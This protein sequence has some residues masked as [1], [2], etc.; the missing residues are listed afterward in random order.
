VT[1][2]L[3]RHL[4]ADARALGPSSVP[5]AAY[6]L[7]KRFGG[8]GLLFG[9]LVPT[10]APAPRLT[11][12]FAVPAEIPAAA[13]GRAAAEAADL[14]A[15]KVRL[16]GREFAL[17][18]APNWCAMVEVA[19]CWPR[20]PWWTIDI[21]SPERPADVK[22]CWELGR[23]RHLVVLARAARMAPSSDAFTTLETHLRSWLDQNPPEVGIHWYSNLEVALR[24]IAWLQIVA[25][26]G[27][28]LPPDL[29]AAMAAVLYQSGRHL[30]AD[31]PYTLASMRNNHLLGD[32][33]GLVAVG[34][35]FPSDRA[36]RRW[37]ALGDR[38]FVRQAARL[39]RDD[40]SMLE[41]SLSYHRFVTEMLAARLLL[42]GAPDVV[43][44]R[45]RAAAVYLVR[46]GV[47]AGPVP[48]YG[49]WDEGR[50]L[51]GTDPTDLRGTVHLALALSGSGAPADWR[52]V[53]DEVAWYCG[54]GRPHQAGEPEEAG[55]AAGGAIGRVARGPVT[56]WLKAGSGPSHGHADLASTPVA[57][58]GQWIVGDPGTGAYNGPRDER[59]YFRCSLAHS[60]IR[61]GGA[62]QLEPH[63]AFRWI[64]SAH[65]A[66]GPALRWSG[67][68]AM[69]GWHDAYRRLDPPRRVA[70]AVMVSERGVAVADWVE[71]E[72]VDYRLSLPL[73]PGLRW[74]DGHVV[75]PEGD[76]LILTVPAPP[77]VTVGQ[78]SPYRGWWSPTYGS[79]EPAALLEMGGRTTGPVVWGVN[80]P[81]TEPALSH[82]AQL[83][84]AGASAAIEF[85][86]GVI[87]LRLTADGREQ[88][89]Y[90]R[91]SA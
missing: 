40:G 46:L 56:A 5:R 1:R 44:K 24:A 31:L 45:L 62:D 83:T 33:L 74:H 84:Y 15:G 29:N 61:V 23:H 13:R 53:H 19:G 75:L 47:L 72:P 11:S 76:R 12:P 77:T 43:A 16:F 58:A 80:A 34:A 78:R 50:V 28:R 42:G 8:H 20:R 38:L 49:D 10:T 37:K 66:I 17:G 60:V 63:R 85:R 65:G 68:V 87:V 35:A 48:Q 91:E 71:G 59:D 70:R 82:G 89:A 7:S 41:D 27:D 36:A 14:A 6:E 4:L 67:G 39:V 54:E 51:V 73:S 9:H 2:S 69:W 57:W 79:A 22:W 3:W 30:V 90:A 26:V 81:G 88:A 18:P 86:A 21:R 52:D 55:R 64:H 25:L 32:S